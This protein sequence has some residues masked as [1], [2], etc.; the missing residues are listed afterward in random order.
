MSDGVTNGGEDRLRAQYEAYPYPARDPADEAR[1]LVTG[2]PGRRDEMAHCLFAGRLPAGGPATGDPGRPMRILVAGG[3]TGDGLVMMAQQLA[4]AGIAAAIDHVDLSRAARSIAEARI[5]ARG[6]TGVSF[7]T[8]SLFDLDTLAPG[9]FDYIDCCGVLHHLDSPEAGLAALVARLAPGG[10]LGLMVYGR[11][12]RSGVYELQ[13]ALATLTGWEG[14]GG[15]GTAG[16]DDPAAKVATARRVL[17][18]LPET[19]RFRR[20]PHLS[21]HRRSDAGLYDLLLHSRDRAYTVPEVEALLASADLVP[22]AFMPPRRYD[23]DRFLTD[24]ALAARAAELSW[25]ARA[26]LAEQLSGAITTHAFYAVRRDEAGGRVADPGDRSLV[27]VLRDLDPAAAAKTV[28]AGRAVTF[29][30]DGVRERLDLPAEAAPILAAIDGSTA[31]GALRDRL[32]RGR[33][34][35]SRPSFDRLWPAVFRALN[36]AGYLHLVAR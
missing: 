23:P 24:P 28:A 11:Y 33:P 7:H 35:L 21:D 20:N 9:P 12:G 31:L 6:L 18:L 27:P 2:S 5:A 34:G 19:N 1:R 3:G 4:D 26:A 22:T 13:A 16:E 36:G 10:G 8:G 17:D 25:I 30:L 15:K 29:A 32:A 14:T